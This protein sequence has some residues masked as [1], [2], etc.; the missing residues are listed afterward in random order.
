MFR[1]NGKI[2]ARQAFIL[3]IMS[4]LSP[5]IRIF[6]QACSAAAKQ[7]AW[8][9]PIIG[10]I[11]FIAL[12][13]TIG[14]L[15]KKSSMT[16]LSD[17]LD[18]AVG[19]IAS[20]ILLM[21]YL[22]WCII[23]FW[24][25]LRYYA[26]RLLASI[27]ANTDLRFFLLTMLIL[28][29][30][31]SR[32]SLETFAR[33]TE[34]IFPVFT[35][36]LVLLSI[37]FLPNVKVSNIWPVTYLDALPSLRASLKVTA[38][39]GYA[40]LPFFF[41]DSIADKGQ[42]K[43]YGWH[44]AA[45]LV[46]ASVVMLVTNVGLL[47]YRVAAHMPI[48]FFSAVKAITFIETFDRFE[49]LLLALWVASDFAL[50]TVFAITIAHIIRSLLPQTEPKYYATPITAAG[51]VGSQ[52]IACGRFELEAFSTNF[53]AYVNLLVFFIVPFFVLII[54]RIRKKI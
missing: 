5:A 15:F 35:V 41:G 47:G 29:Y 26:G 12:F 33:F 40:L 21:L 42:I 20:K 8:V 3:F 28:V 51:Y 17:V 11:P 10:A 34:I 50:C 45:F 22:L 30:M 19:K 39:W 23:L 32:G 44:T 36:V 38:I 27:F 7:A 18:A 46:A 16:K 1:C 31:A 24:L 4:T 54:G 52:Y 37:L 43:K 25:Y 53:A 49:S 48:P 14:V 9:A 2:S 6:P 13:L